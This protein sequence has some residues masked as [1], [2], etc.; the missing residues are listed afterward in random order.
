MVNLIRSGLPHNP[1]IS[2]QVLVLSCRGKLGEHSEGGNLIGFHQ[3]GSVD[4]RLE[5][6]QHFRVRPRAAL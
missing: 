2:F 6:F 5:D 4:D 1:E 3:R